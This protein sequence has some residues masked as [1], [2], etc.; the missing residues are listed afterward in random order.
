M[1]PERSV[2]GDKV[3]AR[4]GVEQEEG[5]KARGSLWPVA[6]LRLCRPCRRG[7]GAPAR[8]GLPSPQEAE[9]SPQLPPGPH[10]DWGYGLAPSHCLQPVAW[11][12]AGFSG[13]GFQTAG[14]HQI[15]LVTCCC[16]AFWLDCL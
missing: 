14:A 7:V 11:W 8:K 1:K 6:F 12:A 15:P 16:L 2:E 5:S 10:A 4:L 9:L 3:G 13:R